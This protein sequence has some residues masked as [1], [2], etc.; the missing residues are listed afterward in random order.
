MIKYTVL[1][2]EED[3]KLFKK[4]LSHGQPTIV[5]RAILEALGR[6]FETKGTSDLMRWLYA[7]DSLTFPVR[8]GYKS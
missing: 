6:E 3:L 8:K 4:H 5:F 1:V 2:E 7:G